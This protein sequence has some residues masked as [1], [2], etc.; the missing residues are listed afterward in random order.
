[1]SVRGEVY[2]ESYPIIHTE[3]T[4][5][6][7]VYTLK[8]NIYEDK[9]YLRSV[10]NNEDLEIRGSENLAIYFSEGLLGIRIIE[11]KRIY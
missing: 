6:K 9:K 4:S 3:V 7:T 8:D 5:S 11:K 10:Y 1:M 2:I